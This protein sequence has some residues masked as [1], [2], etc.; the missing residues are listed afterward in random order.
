MR[1]QWH[2]DGLTGEDSREILKLCDL[3][4]SAE[5]MR[6]LVHHSIMFANEFGPPKGQELRLVSFLFFLSLQVCMLNFLRFIELITLFFKFCI[7]AS[8]YTMRC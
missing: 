3:E 2:F 4:Y 5:D 1:F 6:C 7:L 8:A